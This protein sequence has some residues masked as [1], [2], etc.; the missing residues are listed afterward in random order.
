M[1]VSLVG[2]IFSNRLMNFVAEYDAICSIRRN[3][4]VITFMGVFGGHARPERSDA[5]NVVDFLHMLSSVFVVNEFLV[6]FDFEVSHG[7]FVS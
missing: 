5:N 3:H 1:L 6:V 2:Q 7:I 4:S